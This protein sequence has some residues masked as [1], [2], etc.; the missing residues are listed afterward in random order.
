[1]TKKR[2]G[3]V[4]RGHNSREVFQVLNLSLA[5]DVP[6]FD[7]SES[8]HHLAL[9]Y[10]RMMSEDVKEEDLL[11]FLQKYGKTEEKTNY[12]GSP[13]CLRVSSSCYDVHKRRGMLKG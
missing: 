9:L 1:M 13:L 10:R 11:L 6:T 8:K 7:E 2:Q 12:S 4:A 5:N 3:G